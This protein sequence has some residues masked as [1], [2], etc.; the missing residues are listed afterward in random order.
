[1]RKKISQLT[2]HDSVGRLAQM[3]QDG[4]TG[5]LIFGVSVTTFCIAGYVAMYLFFA[6]MT[7]IAAMGVSHAGL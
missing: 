4:R 2:Q 6:H 7:H 5:D 3:Q 1:M